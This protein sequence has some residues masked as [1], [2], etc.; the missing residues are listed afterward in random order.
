MSFIH[1]TMIPFDRILL[2]VS[3]YAQD[4]KHPVRRNDEGMT[5]NKESK[6]ININLKFYL[7]CA[8]SLG[9]HGPYSKP[10]KDGYHGPQILPGKG[11]HDIHSKSRLGK[12]TMISY[13]INTENH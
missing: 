6:K 9:Y 12:K 2:L 4:I 5:P 7:F 13:P 11:T 8:G 1:L 10:G 3:P